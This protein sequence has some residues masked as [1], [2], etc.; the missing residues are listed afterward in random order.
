[1]T[2]G[3]GTGRRRST[4]RFWQSKAIATCF[5]TFR[6]RMPQNTPSRKSQKLT[7]MH[8]TRPSMVATVIWRVGRSMNLIMDELGTSGKS[9]S[10]TGRKE[11]WIGLDFSPSA[12]RTNRPRRSVAVPP[13]GYDRSVP[14]GESEDHGLG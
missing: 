1:M 2:A 11:A 13:P 10:S 9:R 8:A 3:P 6:P 7:A 14:T 5:V 12:T 4:P